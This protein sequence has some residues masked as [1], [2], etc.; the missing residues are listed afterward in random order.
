MTRS[1]H[2][3]W[4][5]DALR[6]G[7][8]SGTDVASHRRHA[9]ECASCRERLAQDE[10]LVELARALPAAPPD[11]L[12]VVRL[13]TNVLRQAARLPPRRSAW[14]AL[15]LAGLALAVVA[16]ALPFV[17]PS[18]PDMPAAP[19]VM[20]DVERGPSRWPPDP[21]DPTSAE[22]PPSAPPRKP[23]PTRMDGPRDT[24][25]YERAVAAYAA[26][27]YA[28]AAR[29]CAAFVAAHP[30]DP[31]TED[32]TFLE[33]SSLAHGGQ[34]AAAGASAERYLARYGESAFHARDAAVLA[35][36]AARDRADC[37]RARELLAL[38]I[39]SSDPEVAAALG[40]CRP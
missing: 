6:E 13:R 23:G 19:P 30:N 26:H 27:R 3:L 4:E 10:R 20:A 5:V 9:A 7:R 12:R 24:S 17:R 16:G 34:G 22:P 37:Q 11:E 39:P 40:S 29:R 18:Q 38:W 14:R 28:E 15:A 2:R 31:E 25:E 8:L 35:A 33:A 1:C 21:P 32:A 36:R